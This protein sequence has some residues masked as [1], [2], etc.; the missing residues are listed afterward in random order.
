MKPP[1][2]NPWLNMRTGYQGGISIDCG[3]DEWG[4]QSSDGMNEAIR[5]KNVETI[6]APSDAR[7]ESEFQPGTNIITKKNHLAKLHKTTANPSP[8][9]NGYRRNMEARVRGLTSY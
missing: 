5:Q 8:N 4:V 9:V 3:S 2:I 7:L 6:S 1:R